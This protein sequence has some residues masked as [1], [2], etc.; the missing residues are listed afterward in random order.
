[1]LTSASRLRPSILSAALVAGLAAAAGAAPRLDD[2]LPAGTRYDPAIP[3]PA[4][5]LGFEVGEWH[6][7]HDQ[8]VAYMRALAAAS[9]RVRLEVTGH[10]HER[11]PLLLLTISSP[12][13]LDRLEAI[14][15]QHLAL[16]DPAAEEPDVASMPVVVHLGYSVHGDEASG[17][18]AS[19]VV[20]YHLAAAQGP[21]IEGLLDDVVVLLDP[22]LNPDGLGRFAQWVNMHRGAVLNPDPAHREH[23]QGWPTGR[24]NHYWFDLNR[25]W[26]L[27]QHPESRARLATFHRWRPNVHT[28]AHE[29][30]TDSTYFFQPGVPSRKHPLTPE[31]NVELTAAIAAYHARALDAK[32]RLYYSEETFDDFYYG[33]GSTYPDV[34]GAVGILFEQASARGHRQE[35]VNGV[36][37]FPTAIDNQITTSFSTLAAARDLRRELLDYQASFYRQAAREAA[38]D[39]VR[40]YV[41][42]HPHDPRR[43]AALI[44][45]LHHHR[46]AVHPLGRAVEVGE[47]TFEP[48]SAWLVPVEQPQYRLVKALFE[49]RTEFADSTFYDVS[50]WT[51]PLAFG[52]PYAELDAAAWKRAQPGPALVEVPAP[53]G[54]FPAA[55]EGVAYAFAWDGYY[56]PRALYRLLAAEVAARL[57]TLPFTADT[58]AGRRDFTYGT[59]VVPM[60]LQTVPRQRVVELL[61]EAARDDGVDVYAIA[62]GLTP[63]GVDLG[64]PNLEPLTRPEVGLVVG[65]GVSMYQAGQVWH[66]LD[67][68]LAM[69]LTLLDKERLGRLDLERYSH[70]IL[71]SGGYDDL[72]EPLVGELRRWIERGGV[73]VAV[74]RAATWTEKTFPAG[75]PAA[76]AAEAGGATPP[77]PPPAA[78]E[79]LP[80][81]ERQ[82]RRAAQLISG[83]IFEVELD[84]THP[85]AFGYREPRLPVFRN[86]TDV[87]QRPADPY[88]TVARYADAPLLAG[89]ASEEN[90]KQI[91]GSPALVAQRLGRG[92]VVRL[93]DDPSFRAVWYGTDKLLANPLFFGSAVGFT[94]P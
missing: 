26:L 93:I 21:E 59:V 11:R 46:I 65:S 57:A 56:A 83:A 60:G 81:A 3:R 17:A 87:L 39:P 69:P 51:L 35:S 85:L 58:D 1:M 10:T 6:V 40:G 73:L 20:A 91:A 68:R 79:R 45:V 12:A 90:L 14:R 36:L 67:Q 47:R 29:M 94:G 80:Y 88:A 75:A 37:T 15:A 63:A 70:L 64:S 28:D 66:L 84:L 25:D 72:G 53:A 34:N 49:T 82:E 22:S 76:P 30:G 38:Q 44:A 31:R 13:N 23:N 77:P 92:L 4:D 8:L 86:G 52:L 89:Y 19:L 5:V 32:G 62:S 71:V 50:A 54:R 74:G 2:Y 27:A 41:F 9:D 18:N 61:G 33:K 7:R 78:A 55:D 24:T 16:S 43:V 48:G 42:G